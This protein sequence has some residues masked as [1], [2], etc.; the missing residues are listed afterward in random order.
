MTREGAGPTW[1]ALSGGGAVDGVAAGS[2]DGRGLADEAVVD[3]GEELADVADGG[4]VT[5]TTALPATKS[6]TTLATAQSAAALA[7]KATV[8]AAKLIATAKASLTATEATT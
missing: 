4:D 6:T 7:A 1:R 8:T 2:D 5:T 3:S